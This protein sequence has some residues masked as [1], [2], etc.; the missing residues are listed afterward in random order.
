MMTKR[1]VCLSRV[2]T[3]TPGG[4]ENGAWRVTEWCDTEAEAAERAALLRDAEAK[5]R[6][7]A[8]PA[9]EVAVFRRI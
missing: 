8:Q 1:Y 7:P 4:L 2:V 6:G 3:N 5:T 9:P